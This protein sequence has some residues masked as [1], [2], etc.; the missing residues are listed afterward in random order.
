MTMG[1]LKRN[2]QHP[3][4]ERTLPL[5]FSRPKPVLLEARRINSIKFDRHVTWQPSSYDLLENQ[6]AYVMTMSASVIVRPIKSSFPIVLSITLRSSRMLV[7][8]LAVWEGD[9]HCQRL[10]LSTMLTTKEPY[11]PRAEG[12]C[13]KLRRQT[14]CISWQLCHRRLRAAC[15]RSVCSGL[16]T[17]IRTYI[18]SDG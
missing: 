15:S 5:G 6:Q 4:D 11:C 10:K 17:E 13:M 8:E 1:L 7:S 9:G 18:L 3:F 12:R 14:S 16:P 2:D